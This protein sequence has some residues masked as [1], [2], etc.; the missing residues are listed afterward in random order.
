MSTSV[1]KANAPLASNAFVSF[2]S[3]FFL[4]LAENGI[5][6]DVDPQTLLD[7]VSSGNLGAILALF[8]ANFLNP[9]TKI[10]QKFREKGWSGAFL[11][12]PNFWVQTGTA[13]ISLLALIGLM[14]P[15]G[16]SENVVNAVFTGDFNL[17]VMAIVVNVLNPLYH[18]LF[19]RNKKVELEVVQA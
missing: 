7:T 8:I 2:L 11:K 14:L 3:V 4:V 1:V 18:F 13:V 5:V 19:R 12:S 16:A 15:E 6:I 17:I 10:V 9:I